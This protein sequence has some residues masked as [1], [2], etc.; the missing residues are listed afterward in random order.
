MLMKL[1]TEVDAFSAFFYCLTLPY[2]GVLFS[3]FSLSKRLLHPFAQRK[4]QF[5][6]SP[7][8]FL[9]PFST[10]Y[11]TFAARSCSGTPQRLPASE[12]VVCALFH[13]DGYEGLIVQWIEQVSPKD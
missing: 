9:S 13:C 3:L 1:M 5:C 4:R 2:C 7:Q 8:A 12:L 10:K 6:L 11:C